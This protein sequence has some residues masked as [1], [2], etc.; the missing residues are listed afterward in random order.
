MYDHKILSI[1]KN[2]K[3]I[4][5]EK[6]IDKNNIVIIDFFNIYCNIVKFNKYKTFSKDTFI[7]CMNLLLEKF[8]D[9]RLLIVSK[10]IFEVE[11]DYIISLTKNFKNITY[12]IV[13]DTFL[14][15]GS[16]RER[17]DFACILFQNFLSNNKKS[18]I[19]VS[20][21]RYK[22]IQTL[23]TNTKT[24]KLNYYHNGIF[25]Y[26]D[27]DNYLIKKYSDNLKNSCIDK[28]TTCNFTLI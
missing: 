2:K 13:E 10:N 20:N 14:P 12:I 15:K 21:D 19:I 23:L 26:L 9:Y 24:F 22:N 3:H 4:I 18:S 11:I 8:K 27:I 25:S 28:I 1:V 6:T 5:L 16:N 17:D 7:L